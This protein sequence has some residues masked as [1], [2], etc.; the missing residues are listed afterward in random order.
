MRIPVLQ[1]RTPRDKVNNNSRNYK[2]YEA[3]PALRPAV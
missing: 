2:E 3:Q 1:M